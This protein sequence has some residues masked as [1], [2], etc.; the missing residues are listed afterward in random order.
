MRSQAPAG[1]LAFLRASAG[2]FIRFDAPGAGTR[3]VQ[4]TFVLALNPGGTTRGYYVDSSYAA[5]GSL[6]ASA[7]TLTTFDAPSSTCTVALAINPAG[8]ITGAYA[9]ASFVFHGFIFLVP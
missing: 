1:N 6:R 3:F 4:G 9:D 2:T 7:G 5:H 8:T